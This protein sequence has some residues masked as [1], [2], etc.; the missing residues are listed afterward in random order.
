MEIISSIVYGIVQG[1]AEF[2]PISSSGH[3][4]ILHSILPL[5]IVSDLGFDVVLH[6]GTLFSLIVYFR[7]E[8][9]RYIRAFF[10]SFVRW[11]IRGNADQRI[12]WWIAIGTIPAAAI[13]FAV[14]GVIE[15][16]FRSVWV[17]VATLAIG[18][19]LFLIVEKWASHRR[20]LSEAGAGS[21]I[22]IGF[23]QAIAL[24]PGVSRSG[25]TIIAGLTAGLKR[26]AAA[27]FAFLLSMP[28]ILGAGIKK[29]AEML[30]SGAVAENWG[31][32]AIGF[33][34]S[35]ISGYLAVAYLLAFLRTKPLTVFAYY[36]FG[37][38]ALLILLLV[39]GV[40]E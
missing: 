13:G 4:V 11:N 33:L 7:S 27:R 28:I 26:E 8:I 35:A 31:I 36:R 16:A 40:I 14:E 9:I 10:Q 30:Q 5:D 34:A 38:S 39:I 25:I 6:F 24:I 15:S 17:V 20:D 21:A 23:A 2:L 12:A 32:Y 18:G 1:L 22:W 3:L 37:L 29:T 19:V